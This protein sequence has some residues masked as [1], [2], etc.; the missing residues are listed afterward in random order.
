[1]QERIRSVCVQPALRAFLGTLPVTNRI[2]EAFAP[3]PFPVYALAVLS[4]AAAVG[5]LLAANGVGAVIGTL[6]DIPA[7]LPVQRGRFLVSVG[8]FGTAALSRFVMAGLPDLRMAMA[9]T[10][11]F[12]FASGSLNP[13]I[14]T[15]VRDGTPEY[16]R[17]RV[18]G[19]FSATAFAAAPSGILIAGWLV[20]VMGLRWTFLAYGALYVGTVVFAGN[21]R[22]LRDLL[23]RAPSV[24]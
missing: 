10:F 23:S 1:M 12:G 8:C 14:S 24:P 5:G 21:S 16:L 17:G 15:A 4:N 13:I 3:V 22:A 6:P 7:S 18:F 20:G 2:D 19:V 11:V 9:I